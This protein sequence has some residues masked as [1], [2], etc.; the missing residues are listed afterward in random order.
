MPSVSYPDHIAFVQFRYLLAVA[1]DTL[2]SII[3]AYLFISP[4]DSLL[5]AGLNPEKESL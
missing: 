5:G 1:S 2:Y 4:L 3:F